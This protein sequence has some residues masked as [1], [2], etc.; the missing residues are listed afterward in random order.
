MT[1][2]VSLLYYYKRC[3][4]IY[5]AVVESADT[6]DLKSLD[7]NI[8]PVQVRSAAPPYTVNKAVVVKKQR[9]KSQINRIF[10]QKKPCFEKQHLRLSFWFWRA[11][12]SRFEIFSK[13][14]SQ[15]QKMTAF[16]T[17]RSAR[18]KNFFE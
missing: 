4:F 17:E 8:V 11:E 15:K 2:C 14:G 1:E 12:L 10:V 6:R 18:K 9:C 3:F 16:L 5:A 13:K 7:R